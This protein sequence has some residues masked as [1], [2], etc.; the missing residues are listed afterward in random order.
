MGP[1]G[2]AP[3]SSF[4][5]TTRSALVPFPGGKFRETFQYFVG[6]S[7]HIA[8][9]S[10]VHEQRRRSGD[11]ERRAQGDGLLHPGGGFGFG[12]TGGRG[13]SLGSRLFG[14]SGQFFIRVAGDDV[15]LCV[16]DASHVLPECFGRSATNAVAVVSSFGGPIV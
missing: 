12:G 14:K 6:Q 4:L 10:S 11:F 8:D 7:A 3:R 1:S 5:R 9:F 15:F 2:A 13:W 16:E